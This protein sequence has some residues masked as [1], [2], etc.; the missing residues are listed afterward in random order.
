VLTDKRPPSEWGFFWTMQKDASAAAMPEN[1]MFGGG[2]SE[3]LWNRF[4]KERQE[5]Y[6]KDV[7]EQLRVQ[8]GLQMT[9]AF[10]QRYEGG[11]SSGDE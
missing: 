11:G 10:R 1:M 6:R 5:Q 2:R 3:T 8:A 4:E 9:D 7:M